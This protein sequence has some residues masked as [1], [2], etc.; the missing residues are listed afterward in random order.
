[1]A[2]IKPLRKI[3]LGREAT[4]GTAVAATTIWRGMGTIEDQLTEVFPPEQVGV[5]GGTDRSYV[6]A[7]LG[8]IAMD[9][10]EA[11]FEQLPHLFEAGIKSVGSGVADGVG[12][13]LI[14]AYPLPTTSKNT[15]K[16]YTLEGGD[17]Q[18]A[19]E[20]E[21]SFVQDLTLEGKAGEALMMSSTWKGR[22]VS[23]STFTPALTL[24]TVEEILFS[25]GKL[26]IDAVG[27][28]IGTT[29]ISSSLLAM[30]AKLTT[31]WIP[32][33]T[34]EGNLYFTFAKI[35]EPELV[36]D[37]TF[38]HDANSVAEKAAWRAKT[39]RLIRL[40]FEG[41]TVATPGTT[42]SKKS[43]ILDMA[44][45]WEKFGKLD[46]QDNND[47]VVGTFRSRYNSTAAQFATFTVVN[48]L[49]TIP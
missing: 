2:G 21:Y 34:A 6:S 10:V 38:E 39:P 31:G 7:L 18:Q 9:P 35:T 29:L 40:L 28:T 13:D 44:G 8:E 46:D 42:Y 5:I 41:N 17:D 32:V 12:T 16:T 33:F 14:Y 25:Q 49:T 37:I 43:L 3:Q 47:I 23:L 20:L 45:K 15:V 27:G 1:M 19:E 22:Q 36:V 30:S 26:Y 11:T 4:A 24:P 48:E